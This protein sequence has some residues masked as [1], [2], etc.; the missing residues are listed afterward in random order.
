ML[1]LVGS[2]YH[3]RRAVPVCARNV[4]GK[5]EVW[6]SLK[7]ASRK[8]AKTLAYML[9][10]ETDRLFKVAGVGHLPEKF[11][12]RAYLAS[13]VKNHPSDFDN[14][15]EHLSANIRDQRRFL[16]S[17]NP[18]VIRDFLSNVDIRDA[19][20]RAE[21]EAL[22]RDLEVAKASGNREREQEL[23]G[24]LNQAMALNQ[25]LAMRSPVPATPPEPVQIPSPPEIEP[26]QRPGPPRLLISKMVNK[27]LTEKKA[28]QKVI[29]D[30]NKTLSLF[31][32][33]F[34][35]MDVR[36]INGNIVGEFRDALL[37]LHLNHGRDRKDLSI[38]EEIDLTLEQDLPTI[39]PKTVKNH[40]ARISPAW[41]DLVN[42]ELVPRNPWTGWQ[43]D[44]SQRV[45]RRAWTDEELMKLVDA[46]WTTTVVSRPTYI[47]MT[48]IGLYSGMRVGEI[49]NLRNKD[50]SEINGIPCFLI[51]EHSDGWKPKTKAGIR[52][53]PIHSRLLEW[54]IMDYMDKRQ[55]YLFSELRGTPSRPRGQS[56]VSEFSKFKT[57]MGLPLAVTFHG[58]RHTVSTRL[59]NVRAD[60]REIWIDAL[61]GHEA[62]HKSMGTLNYTTSID[63]ENLRDVV[64]LIKYPD[65]L[66]LRR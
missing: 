21:I 28:D 27:Y 36:D 33:C 29:K 49:A 3:F 8:R 64:E 58:F 40:L 7:T 56:F 18:S 1:A 44:T 60:I 47:A 57:R 66:S 41:R 48:M 15:A 19:I 51:R 54:G 25:T 45:N 52:T 26:V 31:I 10:G 5:R 37:S 13:M 6:V 4:I 59:R 34:G 22:R 12:L 24:L 30:T 62:S 17:G 9:H 38:Q 39:S 11:D 16:A 23:F 53:V 61:L 35:D 20:M 55:E 50:I 43:F 63:V 65:G 14:P 42:R 32:S 46:E 2:H